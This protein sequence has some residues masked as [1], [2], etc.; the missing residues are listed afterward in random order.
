MKSTIIVCEYGW[1]L[2]GQVSKATKDTI[3]LENASVVRR[4][5]NG[6]GVGALAQKKYKSDYTLDEIGGVEIRTGKVLFQIPCE[7]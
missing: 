5:D 2:V 3:T 7:W 4:W 6:R 1:V